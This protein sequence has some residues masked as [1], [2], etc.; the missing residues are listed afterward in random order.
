LC[1]AGRS[2]GELCQQDGAVFL[3]S[4]F[5]CDLA[6]R[7]ELFLIGGVRSGLPNCL[8]EHLVALK[9]AEAENVS[10]K[11]AQRKRF[12]LPPTTA[13]RSVHLVQSFFSDANCGFETPGVG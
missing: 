8:P 10:R 2:G 6:G 13:V 12:M 7:G 3:G 11:K 4:D 5:L 9:R 1:G